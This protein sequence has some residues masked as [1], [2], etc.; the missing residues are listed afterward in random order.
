MTTKSFPA[1][2]I[3]TNLNSTYSCAAPSDSTAV[4][5]G[6]SS[7]TT[8]L[9]SMPDGLSSWTGGLSSLGAFSPYTGLSGTTEA[10]ACL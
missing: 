9:S 10:M 7:W 2:C 4:G 6:I 8:G 1:P 5:A 3:F